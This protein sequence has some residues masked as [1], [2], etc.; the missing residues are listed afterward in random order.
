MIKQNFNK[1]L[2]ICPKHRESCMIDNHTTL[3]P[4]K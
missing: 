3:N 1:H 4:R 2:N